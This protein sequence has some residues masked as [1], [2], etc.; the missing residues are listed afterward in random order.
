M[1]WSFRT[2]LIL[3]FFLFGIVPALL[4]MW[5]T[6]NAT[7]QLRADRGMMIHRNTF[8]TATT[9]GNSPL[10]LARNVPSPILDEVSLPFIPGVFDRTLR[11]L[12]L[13]TA[14]IALISPEMKIVVARGDEHWQH[15]GETLNETYSELV[16]TAESGQGHSALDT[17]AATP[18]IELETGPLGPEIAGL[19]T[20]S[21]R[22]K[23]DGPAREYAVLLVAPTSSAFE[24]IHSIHYA[25]LAVFAVCSIVTIVLGW[26]LGNRFVR[27]LFRVMEVTKELQNGRLDVR[28]HFDRSDEIGQLGEQIDAV[29]ANLT[30]VI[31]DINAASFSVSTASNQLSASAQELSQGATEQSSTLQEIASSLQMVDGSVKQNALHAQ[32]TALKANEATTQAE[33]GGLAVSETVAAMRQ[34]AQRIKVVED[35]AYQT[36]LLA[37]NAAIEAARAGAQGRGFAVVAGE[38]RKLAERS[39]A[40]AHEIG[41]QASSS[42]KVAEN[43]GQLLGTIVPAIRHTSTLIKEIAAA[44]QEQTTAIHQI[45]VGVRQLEEVVQQNASSSHQLAATASALAG[46]SASLEHLV[47]FFHLGDE[48]AAAS[49]SRAAAPTPARRPAPP[50]PISHVSR[51][52]ALADA[53]PSPRTAESQRPT[54]SETRSNPGGI[55]VNLDDDADFERF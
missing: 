44:S 40:A 37:L 13:R 27:P 51:Q 35:I 31:R 6:F 49:R 53:R 23:E 28:T 25:M 4:M 32:K 48:A 14:W 16:R 11:N 8:R 12:Q 34:I 43:A 52:P 39:Q 42:V 54:H 7:N 18:Y 19:S 5:V 29:V 41:E 24:E 36:N 46:Q 9:L 45:S 30:S 2:K 21:L 26:Y 47:A 38:V 1:R 3:A 55:V 17:D 15:A 22:E 33:Q 20:L 50:T 10:D